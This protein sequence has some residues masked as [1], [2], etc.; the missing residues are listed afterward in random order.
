MGLPF[1]YFRHGLSLFG[2]R[3]ASTKGW[4][5]LQCK[6]E[7]ANWRDRAGKERQGNIGKKKRSSRYSEVKYI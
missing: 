3:Y 2:V 1:S 5:G 4:S 6:A 7:T